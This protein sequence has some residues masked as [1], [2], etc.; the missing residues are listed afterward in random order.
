MVDTC[1]GEEKWH[2]FS[3][4]VVNIK[5]SLLRLQNIEKVASTHRSAS[6]M[7]ENIFQFLVTL[8]KYIANSK[9]RDFTLDGIIEK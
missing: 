5:F 9:I 7:I 4:S 3:L 2:S 6:R 1:L 8:F